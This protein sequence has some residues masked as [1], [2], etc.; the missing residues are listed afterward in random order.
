MPTDPS[1]SYSVWMAVNRQSRQGSPNLIHQVGSMAN[2]EDALERA[3]EILSSLSV[4]EIRV[5]S[6][7]VRATCNGD[8]QDAVE[9]YD[10][11]SLVGVIV[12]GLS[13]MDDDEVVPSSDPLDG[14]WEKKP[15]GQA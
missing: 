9:V 13:V 10:P 5:R 12:I 11:S 3:G 14:W 8:L 15:M 6:V 1:S 2:P 4:L 7:Q